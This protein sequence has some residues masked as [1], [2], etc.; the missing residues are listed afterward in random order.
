MDTS[1]EDD[2]GA[3]SPTKPARTS[4]KKRKARPGRCAQHPKA[5]SVGVCSRCGSF[6]CEECAR[7]DGD[8]V[9]CAECDAR[10]YP[11][12]LPWEDPADP[13]GHFIRFVLTA[14]RVVT[15]P[16]SAFGPTRAPL[17]RAISFALVCEVIAQAPSIVRLLSS[18][19]LWAAVYGFGNRLLL[20]TGSL[21]AVA[22]M[23]GLVANVLG[24]KRSILGAAR[25]L[26]YAHLVTPL[27]LGAYEVAAAFDAIEYPLVAIAGSSAILFA[28][29]FGLWA[30]T[31]AG[32]RRSELTPGRALAVA[33][34]ALCVNV[35]I[36]L[37]PLWPELE[38][39]WS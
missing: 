12:P 26:L 30:L 16:A 4:R 7:P 35:A 29:G 20:A 32:I 33:L 37:P 39:L 17:S 22:V 36:Y 25:A 21:T 38:L 14:I 34:L 24:G 18:F 1:E 27:W 13:S 9:L 8:A 15:Q 19:G 10:V 31:Q 23:H 28:V 11:P 5:Q 6:A 2:G 3:R